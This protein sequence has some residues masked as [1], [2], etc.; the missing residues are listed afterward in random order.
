MLVDFLVASKLSLP[1][2]LGTCFID[3]NEEAIIPREICILL[4]D[5]TE[6]A[7][8]QT[9]AGTFPVKLGRDYFVPADSEF[10]VSVNESGL[11]GNSS[12]PWVVSKDLCYKWSYGDSFIWKFSGKAGKFVRKRNILRRVQWWRLRPKCNP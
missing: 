12:L 1:L 2:I 11:I 3:E 9:S 5:M 6:V 8:A 10:F 4:K 7:I